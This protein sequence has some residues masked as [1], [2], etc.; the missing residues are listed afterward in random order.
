M[1]KKIAILIT[2]M[3]VLIICFTFFLSRII[4][5][6]NIS[7]NKISDKGVNASSDGKNIDNNIKNNAQDTTYTHQELKEGISYGHN[8]EKIMTEAI[9][10][11]IEQQAR[12][13]VSQF[14][15]VG[16]E[17]YLADTIADYDINNSPSFNRIKNLYHDLPSMAK[18]PYMLESGQD[19][20][21][22]EIISGLEDSENFFTSVMWLER[23][24]RESFIYMDDSI[25]PVF[26][27]GVKVLKKEIIDEKDIQDEIKRRFKDIDEV[28]KFEFDIED[29]ILLAYIVKSNNKFHFFKIEEKIKGST[30]YYTIN[31]W[32]DF[33]QNSF[34]EKTGDE[35]MKQTPFIEEKDSNDATTT[36]IDLTGE[37]GD[38]D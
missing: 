9:A 6:N 19:N 36:Y 25:S 16:A 30:L 11:S 28:I 13:K 35:S 33:S 26:Y 3:L 34:N 7:S 38:D 29:N 31:E 17:R 8:G 4:V 37:E 5:K 27:G 10:S 20:I 32:R 14:D 18:F 21:L 15:F 24:D 1:N 2:L 12:N 22:K 23:P